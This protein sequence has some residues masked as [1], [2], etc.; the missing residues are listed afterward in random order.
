MILPTKDDELHQFLKE[1]A[2]AIHALH[3]KDTDQYFIKGVGWTD[4]ED[5]MFHKS[6]DWCWLLFKD[7]SDAQKIE[8]A[9]KLTMPIFLD[10]HPFEISTE[11]LKIWKR[12]SDE[13]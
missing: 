12:D 11:A 7:M 2:E 8:L 10:N 4:V 3:N 9:S 6:R 5:M 13:T 1:C